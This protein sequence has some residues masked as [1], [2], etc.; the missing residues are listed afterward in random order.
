MQKAGILRLEFKIAS[1]ELPV[2]LAVSVQAVQ[3]WDLATMLDALSH[4][5]FEPLGQMDQ[6]VL[7]LMTALLLALPSAKWVTDVNA[8]S[9]HTDFLQFTADEAHVV[10]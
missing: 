4:T 8:F 3:S 10:L 9:V 5:P 7:L 6:K 1:S 2:L